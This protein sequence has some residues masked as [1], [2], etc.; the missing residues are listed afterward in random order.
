[1]TQR[2][3]VASE[4][5]LAAAEIESPPARWRQ[6]LEELIAMEAPVAVVIRLPRPGDELWCV[7]LPGGGEIR[8]LHPR[9]LKW[10]V[11]RLR[12]Q[13]EYGADG[14]RTR[15]LQ[16]ATLA[17]SQLSYGPKSSVSLAASS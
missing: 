11:G 4:A 9:S 15:G 16:R 8:R 6:E 14:A 7:L 2:L 12:H 13:A 1:V 17:L 10:R 5:P 3:Q